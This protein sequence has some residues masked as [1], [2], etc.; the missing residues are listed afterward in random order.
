MY[1]F[2]Y[3]SQNTGKGTYAVESNIAQMTHIQKPSCVLSEGVE[4][5]K[6]S[7]WSNLLV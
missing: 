1:L 6:S 4:E 2:A 3:T 5:M 7:P